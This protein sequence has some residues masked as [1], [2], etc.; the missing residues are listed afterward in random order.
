[1]R[2][3]LHAAILLAQLSPATSSP[4][5]EN[6]FAPRSAG[7][8]SARMHK[9]SRALHHEPQMQCKETQAASQSPDPAKIPMPRLLRFGQPCLRKQGEQLMLYLPVELL[10]LE[11]AP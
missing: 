3:V 7:V 2:L 4:G 5:K 10:C 6:L 8:C 1:M 9:A 11:C